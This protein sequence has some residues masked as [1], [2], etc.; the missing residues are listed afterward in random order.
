[1]KAD[2]PHPVLHQRWKG[3]ND[4]DKNEVKVSRMRDVMLL[5]NQNCNENERLRTSRARVCMHACMRACM[6]MRAPPKMYVRT[7][8]K[9]DAPAVDLLGDALQHVR[10]VERVAFLVVAMASAAAA[11]GARRGSGYE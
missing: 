8:I 9:Q 7:Y 3:E 10:N 5:K 1:M 6:H 2:Q 4:D 11:A